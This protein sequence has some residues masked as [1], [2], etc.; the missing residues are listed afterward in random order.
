LPKV[1]WIA[2]YT[3][4]EILTAGVFFWLYSVWGRGLPYQQQFRK[5]SWAIQG[6]SWP[7][8]AT[9]IY[10]LTHLGDTAA[11]ETFKGVMDLTA[12][13]PFSTYW[14]GLVWGAQEAYRGGNL[15]D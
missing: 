2:V 5:L 8:I 14:I 3:G 11:W 9:G 15:N 7:T 6:N 10:L 13:G 1:W 12:L 4:L